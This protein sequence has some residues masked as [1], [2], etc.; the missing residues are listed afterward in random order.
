[1][2]GAFVFDIEGTWRNHEDGA[3][4]SSTFHFWYNWY[5]YQDYEDFD[6]A[7]VP[8]SRRFRHVLA[9]KGLSIG[10]QDGYISLQEMYEDLRDR[11]PEE[12]FDWMLDA[13]DAE[14][15]SYT[16]LGG[17]DYHCPFDQPDFFVDN[18]ILREYSHDR[19]G[20]T[21]DELHTFAEQGLFEKDADK[22]V[23]YIHDHY[24]S[25]E[26]EYI[27]REDLV[28][29]F[30]EFVYADHV[31][32][33]E[34]ANEKPDSWPYEGEIATAFEEMSPLAMPYD[35]S[36]VNLSDLVI[37]LSYL[38]EPE[39]KELLKQ[40]PY[41]FEWWNDYHFIVRYLVGAFVPEFDDL[42]AENIVSLIW[43]VGVYDLDLE[44]LPGVIREYSKTDSDYLTLSEQTRLI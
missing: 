41:D 34:W 39:I 33:G 3:Y 24:S 4:N 23:S 32:T 20:L 7:E 40:Y 5:V 15:N 16:Y 21:Y 44:A 31:V 30:E 19:E 29:F 43:Y 10:D 28:R 36:P 35:Y 12:N 2:F 27:R 6:F 38:G 42:N 22:A 37:E 18:W 1:M 13:Y 26:D 8:Y 25:T 9:Y 11:F 14:C 17:T